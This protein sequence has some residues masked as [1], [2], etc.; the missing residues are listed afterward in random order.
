MDDTLS[1]FEEAHPGCVA[2]FIFD[3]SSA[4][5]S[6]GDDALRAF[7]MNKGDGGKQWQ[8]KD[9]RI[10]D[11]NPYPEYRG[12]EQKMTLPDGTQKGL[13]RVL[14]EHGFDVSGMRS[15]C[16]P[17]NFRL[18]ESLLEQKIK[19]RGHLCIFLPKFQCELNPIEMY[20]GWVKYR[21]RQIW[22]TT[23]E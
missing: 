10:P 13:E 2:L 22:K 15:K 9:T 23:F 5:A 12:W 21:Y 1:I 16:R 8:Q 3:Q 18:Q 6:L 17:D 20:W 4:H 14:T 19:A 11:T 7:E